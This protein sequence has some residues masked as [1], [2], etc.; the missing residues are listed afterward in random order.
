MWLRQELMN[1]KC[2]DHSQMF[3]H[4]YQLLKSHLERLLQPLG[5]LKIL[6]KEM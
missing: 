3:H 5:F 4:N 2:K 1:S 6:A